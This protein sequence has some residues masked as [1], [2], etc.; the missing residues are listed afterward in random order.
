M[1]IVYSGLYG[2]L[3]GHH[4]LQTALEVKSDLRFKISDLNY[5]HIYVHIVY[6]VMALFDSLR[7]HYSLQTAFE[8]KSDLGDLHIICG[9]SL[10]LLYI[11][12]SHFPRR[13]NDPNHH[14]LLLRLKFRAH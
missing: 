6:M 14:L 10:P 4:S 1:H 13:E 2:Q 3:R 8:V 7:G 12:S 11:A 5:L 9:Q